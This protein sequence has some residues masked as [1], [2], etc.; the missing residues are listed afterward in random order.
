M[1]DTPAILVVDDETELREMLVEYLGGKGFH[2]LEAADGAAA[3]VLMQSHAVQLAVLDI[4]MPGE[5]GLSLA[6]HLREHHDIAIIMLTAAS[7]AVDRVI[8]LEVGADDYMP[9]PFDPR[10]LLARIRALLRRFSPDTGAA[11]DV[12]GVP[13]GACR[14]DPDTRRLVAAD[15][16]EVALTPHECAL[17]R[18]FAEHPNRVFTRDEILAAT[19][20]PDVD[21]FDRSIDIR[22]ARLRRKIEPC[23]DKPEIIKTVRGA[24]YMYVQRRPGNP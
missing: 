6:R 15:G 16:Q 5:D 20:S 19:G 23:P 14:F 18:L 1:T 11:S 7:D 3:R 22:I 9:K 12:S 4:Q 17:L 13:F 8:G 21:P 10:E 24:G 2:V